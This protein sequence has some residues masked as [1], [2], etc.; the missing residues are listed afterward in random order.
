MRRLTYY[1]V[2]AILIGFVL[3][4]GKDKLETKPSLKLKGTSG[5]HVAQGQ[6]FFIIYFDY[7]DKEGDIDSL[8]VKKIRHN[9][10]QITTIRDSFWITLPSLQVP[11][12]EGEM[13][14]RLNEEEYVAAVSP[15]GEPDSLTFKFVLKDKAGNTSDTVNL[16]DI[17]IDR[18]Q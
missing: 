9:E 3:S 16:P 11:K 5:N 14:I 15:N 2:L 4:C 12:S 1:S 7:A 18:G 17:I 10:R 8:W 6:Q 13:E